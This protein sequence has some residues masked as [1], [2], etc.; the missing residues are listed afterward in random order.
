MTLKATKKQTTKNLATIAGEIANAVSCLEIASDYIDADAE[1]YPDDLLLDD[2]HFHDLFLLDGRVDY[3]VPRVSLCLRIAEK[4]LNA[5]LGVLVVSPDTDAD[6]DSASLCE[7]CGD[8]I[9]PFTTVYAQL[10]EDGLDLVNS[11]DY[12][13]IYQEWETAGRPDAIAKFIVAHAA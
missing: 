7:C 2:D 3:A 6:D 12:G 11:Q 13:R 4:L 8:P 5:A 10:D 9:D 1:E